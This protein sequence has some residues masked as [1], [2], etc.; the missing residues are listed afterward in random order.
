MLDPDQQVTMILRNIR[1]ACQAAHLHISEDLHLLIHKMLH[2]A[3]CHLNMTLYGSHTLPG[4]CPAIA[5]GDILFSGK[6]SLS[7]PSTWKNNQITELCMHKYIPYNKQQWKDPEQLHPPSA[8]A[9]CS[10]RSTFLLVLQPYFHEIYPPKCNLNI[11]FPT[12]SHMSNP[13]YPWFTIV[14][15]TNHKIPYEIW[16]CHRNGAEDSH[17]LGHAVSLCEQFMTFES[18]A[19]SLSS[20]VWIGSWK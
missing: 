18:S 3:W 19:M 20:M 10:L 2:A 17:F 9:T 6:P 8:P 1:A 15:S 4:L 5:V 11:L 7:N 14:T 13:P 16:S 12:W